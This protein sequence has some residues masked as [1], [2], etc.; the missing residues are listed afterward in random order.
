[1]ENPQEQATRLV[2]FFIQQKKPGEANSWG[3]FFNE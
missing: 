1:M 2:Y 3:Y